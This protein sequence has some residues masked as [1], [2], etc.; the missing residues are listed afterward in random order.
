LSVRLIAVT[1]RLSLLSSSGSLGGRSIG[2]E[3]FLSGN[4]ITAFVGLAWFSALAV[5]GL[6][7]A[8][9]GPRELRG[10]EGKSRQSHRLS[11]VMAA[12]VFARLPWT[13][14]RPELKNDPSASLGVAMEV[15][16]PWHSCLAVI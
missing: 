11:L 15:L 2:Q 6:Q 1:W 4:I 8:A 13:H 14:G 7:R 5:E 12:H 3:V 10:L 16:L 9:I